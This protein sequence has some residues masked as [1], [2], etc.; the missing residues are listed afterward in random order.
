LI[1]CEGDISFKKI[2]E[3]TNRFGG[4]LNFL[5]NAKGSSGIVGSS[6]KNAKGIFIA[7]Q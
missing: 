6:S 5:F 4:T 3:L 2:I 1:F 7:G